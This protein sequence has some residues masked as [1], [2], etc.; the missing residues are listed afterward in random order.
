MTF[1][2]E[3]KAKKFCHAMWEKVRLREKKSEI[4]DGEFVID[5]EHFS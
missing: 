2:Q 1:V 4:Y 3:K 5:R